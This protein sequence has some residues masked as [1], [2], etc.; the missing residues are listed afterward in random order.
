MI[1]DVSFDFKVC[2]GSVLGLHL[3]SNFALVIVVRIHLC[4][5]TCVGKLFEA[6]SVF[7]LCVLVCLHIAW[8]LVLSS[9]IGIFIVDM[10][11][12]RRSSLVP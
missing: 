6:I 5:N 3:F 10:I 2:V 11:S 1:V 7:K 12:N 9:P 8:V 4:P